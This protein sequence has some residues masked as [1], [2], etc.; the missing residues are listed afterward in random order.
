MIDSNRTHSAL[1]FLRAG[2]DGGG[3]SVGAG[4]A[5]LDDLGKAAQA[6]D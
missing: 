5:H 3:F 2:D 6:E 1:R 4:M